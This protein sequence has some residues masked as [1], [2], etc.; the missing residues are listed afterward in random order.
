MNWTEREDA[1]RVERL[2]QTVL[3]LND[4]SNSLTLE[5]SKIQDPQAQNVAS[6]F[7]MA[8]RQ[9]LSEEA[10][11]LVNALGPSGVSS[12]QLATIGFE[13]RIIEQNGNRGLNLAAHNNQ[14]FSSSDNLPFSFFLLGV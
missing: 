6:S 7:L 12:S 4:L 11:E 5:L 10:F 13:D 2:Q 9:L 14:S 1:R 8:Q 3:K